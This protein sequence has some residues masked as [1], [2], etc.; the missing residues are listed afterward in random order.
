MG[1][2]EAFELTEPCSQGQREEALVALEPGML[3]RNLVVRD[4]MQIEVLRGIA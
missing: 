3:V 2:D 1:A 4:E